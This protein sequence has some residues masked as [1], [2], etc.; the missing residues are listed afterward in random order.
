MKIVTKLF[1]TL[2][3]NNQPINPPAAS[4]NKI[5]NCGPSIAL[6][7]GNYDNSGLEKMQRNANNYIICDDPYRYD[8]LNSHMPSNMWH[9]D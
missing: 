4:A 7:V 9:H 6:P 2:N 5:V 1:A 8:M 3:L